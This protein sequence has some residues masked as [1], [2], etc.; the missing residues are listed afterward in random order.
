MYV[1]RKIPE[2]LFKFREEENFQAK[3]HYWKPRNYR[4]KYKMSFNFFT[5]FFSNAAVQNHMMIVKSF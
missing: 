2:I 4:S 3:I 5:E 1:G